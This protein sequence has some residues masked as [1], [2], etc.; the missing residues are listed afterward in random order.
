MSIPKEGAKMNV[1]M[2][3]KNQHIEEGSRVIDLLVSVGLSKRVA[4]WVNDKRLMQK[5]YATRQLQEGDRVK[6]IRP[7]GGG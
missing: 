3:G 7:L 2:N 6:V 1:N 4:V 5:D